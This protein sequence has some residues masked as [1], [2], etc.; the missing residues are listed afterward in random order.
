MT[1]PKFCDQCGAALNPDAR[2]CNQCGRPVVVPTAAPAGP[3]PRPAPQPVQPIQ[4]PV[5][6]TAAPAA[7]VAS[8]GEPVYG[9]IAGAQRRKGLFGTQTYCVIVTPQRL[10]FAEL[11]SQMQKDAVRDA[12]E[13]AKAQGKGFLGRMAAQ[14]G[15]LQRMVDKYHAMPVEAALRETK[16]NFFILNSHV[17]KVSIQEKRDAEN[18]LASH[19]LVIEANSG[20]YSF[21]LKAGKPKEAKEL[22]RQALGAVVR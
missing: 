1:Q 4:Q 21:E 10:V 12:N 9:V 5:T 13:E 20:K 22:L 19:Y 17:R 14:W 16:D 2:F 11:T 8:S 18:D 15:W 6:P 7:Q 3:V